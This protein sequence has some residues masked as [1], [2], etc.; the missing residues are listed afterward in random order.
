MA[1]SSRAPVPKDVVGDIKTAGS[2]PPLGHAPDL[3]IVALVRVVITDVKS[4][5]RLRKYVLSDPGMKI[6]SGCKA[7]RVEIFLGFFLVDRIT[8]RTDHAALRSRCFCKPVGGIP[9]A[10]AK[11]KY[12]A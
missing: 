9:V 1:F 6:H 4:A 8:I 5:F 11:F 7:G 12:A 3:G 10:A 2:Y